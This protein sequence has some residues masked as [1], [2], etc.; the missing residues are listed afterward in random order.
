[1][2]GEVVRQAVPLDEAKGVHAPL[3]RGRGQGRW[4]PLEVAG[5]EARRFDTDRLA[6]LG[7]DE[8]LEH[9]TLS[10]QGG[11]PS[12]QPSQLKGPA[13]QIGVARRLRWRVRF[14]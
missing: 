2:L 8:L 7:A 14:R 10:L 1:R 11:D 5:V 13:K 6:E 9:G 3:A 4:Q 12:P